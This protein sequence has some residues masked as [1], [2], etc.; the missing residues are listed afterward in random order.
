MKTL[1]KQSKLS[2]L[3]WIAF[4]AA[5]IALAV[6]IWLPDTTF[7]TVEKFPTSGMTEAEVDAMYGKPDAI[8][9][10]DEN[11][12]IPLMKTWNRGGVWIAVEFGEDLKVM[13]VSMVTDVSHE[14]PVISFPTLLA[15]LF[16]LLG[17]VVGFAYYR[18]R[19]KERTR[20]LE[21]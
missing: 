18:E 20:A 11:R 8:R 1:M 10:A 12:P 5:L 9:P 15:I 3:L 4:V 16:L 7:M 14:E 6:V 17:A 13:S 2:V 19:R 21:R